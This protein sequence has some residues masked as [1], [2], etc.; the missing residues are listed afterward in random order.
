MG[1]VRTIRKV[2]WERSFIPN[3]E[4][5]VNNKLFGKR[6]REKLGVGYNPEIIENNKLFGNS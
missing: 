6:G 1:E 5:V 4:I 3:P 2:G